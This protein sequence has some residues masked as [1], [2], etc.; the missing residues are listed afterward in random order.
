M[1]NVT[2]LTFDL[3]KNRTTLTVRWIVSY[4]TLVQQSAWHNR[5]LPKAPIDDAPLAR[6][7]VPRVCDYAPWGNTVVAKARLKIAL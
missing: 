6:I 7:P 2:S 5:T 1:L 4:W 3:C